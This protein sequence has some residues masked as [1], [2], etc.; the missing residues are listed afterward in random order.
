GWDL[1][2]VGL[3]DAF[4]GWLW[5][6]LAGSVTPRASRGRIRRKLQI[7]LLIAVSSR[8]KSLPQNDRPGTVLHGRATAR[9]SAEV[10]WTCTR[11]VNLHVTGGAIVVFRALIML[12][13]RRFTPSHLSGQ[14]VAGQTQ[15]VDRAKSQEPRIGRSV[16]RVTRSAAFGL[17]RGMFV[18][19]RTLLVDVTLDASG[20][21]ACRQSGLFQLEPAMRI[22]AIAAAYRAFQN[23]MMERHRER[24][25][26][27]SMTTGAELRIVRAQH[28]DGREARLLS[29]RRSHQRIG[30]RHISTDHV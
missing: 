11:A 12:R 13:A 7:L 15:L 22:V 1:Q 30:A 25:L 16:R 9:A 2:S 21:S 20:I 3:V 29:I 27:F 26:Y 14:A 6:T 28:S 23:L 17:N 8:G 4:S 5:V 10:D 24:R 19:E 18:R